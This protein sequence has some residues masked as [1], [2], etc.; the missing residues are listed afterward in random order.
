M[1]ADP[2]YQNQGLSNYYSFRV[3]PCS[4]H[5]RRNNNDNS[6]NNSNDEDVSICA[7]DE[8]MRFGL[9]AM[10]SSSG[11]GGGGTASGGTKSRLEDQAKKDY[12]PEMQDFLQESRV[13]TTATATAFRNLC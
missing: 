3:G 11:L 9:T 12:A 6:N 1:A 5:H 13:S 7:S 2:Y 10:G 8:L 4:N